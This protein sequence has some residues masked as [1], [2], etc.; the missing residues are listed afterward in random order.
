MLELL[1]VL[2][3]FGD[4]ALP[5]WVAEEALARTERHISA[6]RPL[7]TTMASEREREREKENDKIASVKAKVN[8]RR[9]QRRESGADF[10]IAEQRG[11]ETVSVEACV[12]AAEG[13]ILIYYYGGKRVNLMS[14]VLW[15]SGRNQ[16][17]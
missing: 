6:G 10:I 1:S 12:E 4:R 7:K 5:F 8:H 13:G 9:G 15:F 14:G 3:A 17:T 16:Q 2:F 11:S